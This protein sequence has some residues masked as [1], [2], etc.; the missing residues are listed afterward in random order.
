[1]HRENFLIFFFSQAVFE[2]NVLQHSGAVGFAGAETGHCCCFLLHCV[3]G[4]LFD[5]L[6]WPNEEVKND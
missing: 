2:E 3:Y 4:E 6:M 5:A 1:M